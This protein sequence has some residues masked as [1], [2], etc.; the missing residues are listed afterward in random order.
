MSQTLLTTFQSQR[1]LHQ[2]WMFFSYE[3]SISPRRMVPFNLPHVICIRNF[4]TWAGNADNMRIRATF[5][6][7]WQTTAANT[8]RF[9]PKPNMECKEAHDEKTEGK[10]TNKSGRS[11]EPRRWREQSLMAV[12]P[13]FS[14][15]SLWTWSE[16]PEAWL[17]SRRMG[18][19][20]FNGY[21]RVRRSLL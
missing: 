20:R 14:P 13:H 10:K 17:G 5:R 16:R 8:R 15:G 6:P 2:V 4:Q 21:C 19:G 1:D 12:F 11:L 3:T 18:A 9:V 7:T